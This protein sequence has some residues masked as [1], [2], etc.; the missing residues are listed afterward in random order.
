HVTMKGEENIDIEDPWNENEASRKDS[1]VPSTEKPREDHR[2]N[3]ELDASIN[4]TNSINTASDG[5][6]TNNVNAVSS[7]VNAAGTKVN[8]VDPKKSIELPNDPNMLELED[9]FYSNDDEDVGAEADMNNLDAFMPISP[10]LTTR[11]HKDH[12]VE[13]II[14]DLNSAPQTRR[15]TKNLKEHGL[16]SPVQQRIN[17]KNFQNCLFVYPS[18]IEAMQDVYRNKK[19]E[20]GIV[21]KNKARLVTQGYTQEEGIDYDDLPMIGCTRDYNGN[22]TDSSG[23]G[24]DDFRCNSAGIPSSVHPRDQD[25]PH[26]DAHPEGENSE[27]RQKTSKHGTFMFGESA[28]GQDF[29]SE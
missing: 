6:I 21:I 8:T 27:K 26:D 9:I 15:M 7:T 29:K 25:D 3:Q 17:H 4:S 13:Q 10:I 1:E 19:D 12:P 28:S 20:R 16:F 18:W 11:I 5:N 2:V 14:E 22:T 24:K 23:C